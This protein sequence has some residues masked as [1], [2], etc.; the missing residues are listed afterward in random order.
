MPLGLCFPPSSLNATVRV[1]V[2]KN[3]EPAAWAAKARREEEKKKRLVVVSDSL[4]GV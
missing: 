3:A 4:T 1:V 2:V